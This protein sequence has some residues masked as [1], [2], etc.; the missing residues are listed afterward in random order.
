MMTICF[1]CLFRLSFATAK[2]RQQR[3]SGYIQVPLKQR[4]FLGARKWVHTV[5]VSVT[6]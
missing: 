1:V 5:L 6:V 3:N 4:I 2:H